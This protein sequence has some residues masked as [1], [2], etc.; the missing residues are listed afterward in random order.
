MHRYLTPMPPRSLPIGVPS[1]PI[2]APSHL[3]S[4]KVSQ[5]YDRRRDT[6]DS[7]N[8]G[9]EAGRV[10]G[11]ISGSQRRSPSIIAATIPQTR[12]GGSQLQALGN[13]ELTALPELLSEGSA[14]TPL[15]N[16]QSSHTLSHSHPLAGI[17]T[18]YI[19]V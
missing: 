9:E 17:H 5:A 19:R 14:L 7:S 1:R 13:G 16:P 10:G 11:I 12:S 15:T 4:P 8:I 3:A 2:D 18:Q 6:L